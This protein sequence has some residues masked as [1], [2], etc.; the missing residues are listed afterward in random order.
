MVNG[1]RC[2][3][4]STKVDSEKDSFCLNGQTFFVTT[5]VYIMLNKPQ[6]VISSTKDAQHK[7]VMDLFA[8]QAQI[9]MQS[10]TRMDLF[11]VGRLDIDTEGLLLITNDG[12]LNHKLTSPKN[13]VDKK[14]LVHLRD[15]IDMELFKDY[16]SRMFDGIQFYDGTICLPANLTLA[17]EFNF[18]QPL[19]QK[20]FITIQEGKYH[21][22]KKMFKVLKNEVLYLKRV[23]MGNLD[24]DPLLA[25]GEYRELTEE[26]V[27]NLKKSVGLV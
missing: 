18:D 16:Q 15:P 19:I 17:G 23:K 21:Q 4:P 20:V 12:A 6:N 24:L 5:F 26:E 25:P 11:P 9:G 10:W 14:Y 7:T 13:H 2:V 27:F 3:D 22:V 1:N 8:E